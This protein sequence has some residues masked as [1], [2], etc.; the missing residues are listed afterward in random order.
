[1][2][3]G[4]ASA[5]T[6]RALRVDQY[7]RLYLFLF[8]DQSSPKFGEDIPTSPEVIEA[9]MLNFKPN[10]KFSRFSKFELLYLGLNYTNFPLNCRKTAEN[11]PLLF[12]LEQRFNSTRSDL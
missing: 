12:F 7:L 4:L 6:E 8:V 1:M 9:H 5:Y 2:A 10:F 3:Y 11:L